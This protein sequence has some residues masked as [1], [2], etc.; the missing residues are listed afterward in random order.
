M[1]SISL[2]ELNEHIRRALAL[3]FP[4]A[5]WIRAE[6]GQLKESRG[7][8]Y[9]NLVQKSEE[10]DELIA[11]SDA[12][13]WGRKFKSLARQHGSL[14]ND[15]LQ[16]GLELLLKV[17]VE[18]HESFGF[19]LMVEDIDPNFTLGKL[20]IERQKV[21]GKLKKKRL[22]EKNSLLTTPTVLQRIA[23]LSNSTAAGY[24]DFINQIQSNKYGHD[25]ELEL[26]PIALQGAKVES[27]ILEKF[28]IIKSR[29]KEFD[30]VVIIR[31][32]GS[33]IDLAAFDSFEI[34]K[35]IANFKLPVFTG[36]GH[37]I[38]EG[39]ADYVAHTALK[40]PTAV[41]EFII[42]HNAYFEEQLMRNWL[43]IREINTQILREAKLQ[44]ESIHQNIK[45]L[46]LENIRNQNRMIDYMEQ[47]IPRA[48][49]GVLK[50]EKSKVDNIEKLCK[51]L[52]PEQILKR[53]YSITTKK[54]KVIKN[55]KDLKKGDVVKTILKK[56]TVESKVE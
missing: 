6:V 2:F 43:Q 10:T 9:F 38:D 39:I 24:H 44:L 56:G 48:A 14:I 42:S 13:L 3:N 40:T 55:P 17:Q 51:T 45:H 53:G 49:K 20:A 50:T 22:L 35:T 46:S 23:V 36:I 34:G 26:F 4:D 7:H 25:Y 19:K 18:F 31:G 15:L 1:T 47:E 28:E 41:A 30:C 32:G 11:R 54:G 27:E 12:V 37:E 8:F 16:E 29:K 52:S 5:V 33:K 21:L